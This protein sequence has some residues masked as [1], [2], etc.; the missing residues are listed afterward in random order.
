MV[1]FVFKFS[2]EVRNLAYSK[3]DPTVDY[4]EKYINN[5]HEFDFSSDKF[6]YPC[7]KDMELYFKDSTNLDI[8]M[9]L[10]VLLN[11]YGF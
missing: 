3:A 8:K 1:K 5:F 7:S 2:N 9:Y 11:L 4:V 6:R 10:I